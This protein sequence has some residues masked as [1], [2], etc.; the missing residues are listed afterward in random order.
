SYTYLWSDNSSQGGTTATGLTAG[1]YT[2]TVTEVGQG[3]CTGTASV[4]IIASGALTVSASQTTATGCASGSATGSAS[5]TSVSGGDGS[6]TYLW[7]D[8]SSQGGTTATGLTA[9]N[10]TVTVTEVG[11]GG[12]TGTASVTINASGSLTVSASQTT[13]TGCTFGSATGSASITSVSGGDGSYTYLWSDNS[14]QGGTTATGLTAGNYTV[15][16]T[17]V[18]QGGCTGTASVTIIA[19]GALTVSAS[20]TTATGCASGSA[21]GSASV[22]SVTGGDGSYTYLWSDNSSQGGTTATGLTAGNYTV[23]V[24]EVGQGGCTGT[25]SV[26]IIA[27]G[28]LTVSASQTTATGCASGSATGSASV[29][30]VTG[31]DGSYTYLWSDN[32]SQGGTTATGLTAGNYTVTVTEVGQGGCTG[33]ASVTINAS[34]SLTVSASQTTSTGCTFGSATGSASITSVSGGDGSYTYLWSDNSSQGGTTA[35]GLTAGNYTVT[36]TEV[37]QGGCTGTASVTINAS[38]S[39]TVSASQT[40]ATGCASGSAVGKASVTYVTGGDGS[41]TYLWSD[42]SSQGGTTATGLTAGNYT[43]TVTEVGQGGCTATA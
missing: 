20:Q 34:G 24:T 37:G 25:A 33:T 3:G 35:T 13:S 41:Y 22:T 14:S 36:V 38:G 12:C 2:V 18:G 43:V 5:I 15:T 30:S 6:Y 39:L 19:S 31:G 23:T 29:T 16:V 1:N 32:S 42:N 26:T 8:N 4:T 28:A 27:S 7:S 10:Y 9:G 40:T 21:T 17:E 11:Q